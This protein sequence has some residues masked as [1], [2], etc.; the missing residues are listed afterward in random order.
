MFAKVFASLWQGSMVGRSD[1]QLVFIYMLANCDAKGVFDQTPEVVSALTGLPLERVEE[2][3]RILESPDPRSRTATDDGRRIVLLDEHRDW[4]WQIV[5]YVEYRNSRDEE[6]RKDQNREAARR[7]RERTHDDASAIVSRNDDASAIVSRNDD[8]SSSVITRHH[9]SAAVSHGQP[10]QKQKQKQREKKKEP[11]G[12]TLYAEL[13]AEVDTSDP[14]PV[15]TRLVKYLQDTGTSDPGCIL[16]VLRHFKQN[17]DRIDKPLAY[18]D[19][20][21]P[22]RSAII[23]QHNMAI[24][25]QR[26]ERM[27]RMRA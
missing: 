16:A 5:N 12:S 1:L 21:G 8:A 23:M 14:R 27:K 7:Y 17:R 26:Q 9:A 15:F 18:Y 2:A 6:Q 22:A 4:G 24:A 19:R 20:S 13:E 25:E 10:K 3:I 11:A